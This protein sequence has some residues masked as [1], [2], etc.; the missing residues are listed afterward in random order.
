MHIIRPPLLQKKKSSYFEN[1]TM[2]E[3][4]TAPKGVVLICLSFSLSAPLLYSVD[5]LTDPD[6]G[7]PLSSSLSPTLISG[8]NGGR[9]NVATKMF[10][11]TPLRSQLGRRFEAFFLCIVH[12]LTHSFHIHSLTRTHFH[13]IWLLGMLRGPDCYTHSHSFTH[14]YISTE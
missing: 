6:K 2:K 9:S 14:S 4:K 1:G 12:T 3:H 11:M 13:L 7:M 5:I 10:T 8:I